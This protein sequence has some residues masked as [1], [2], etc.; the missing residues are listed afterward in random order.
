MEPDNNRNKMPPNGPKNWNQPQGSETFSWSQGNVR[1]NKT[2]YHGPG[3]GN[4]NDHGTWTPHVPADPLKGGHVNGGQAYGGS[5]P[6]PLPAPS[7]Q[8][9]ASFAVRRLHKDVKAE[10]GCVNERHKRCVR[11]WDSASVLHR[12]NWRRC[13]RACPRCP[14]HAQHVGLV[15][16]LQTR[17][18]ELTSAGLPFSAP[19]QQ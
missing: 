3:T 10:L 13:V 19:R 15:S 2:V 11:C 5:G 4:Q 14:D 1:V 16:I 7:Q 6:G 8:P 9:P 18:P 12:E 17:R